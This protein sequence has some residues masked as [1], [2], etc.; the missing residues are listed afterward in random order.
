MKN[1]SMFS[2]KQNQTLLIALI[3]CLL[4]TACSS[5]AIYNSVQHDRLRECYE[6]SDENTRKECLSRHQVS[7]E[8]Y[9]Y[10]RKHLKEN[11]EK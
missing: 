10:N 2:N 8:K 6:I 4:L 1:K 3:S 5:K 11:H 9:E 7:Y